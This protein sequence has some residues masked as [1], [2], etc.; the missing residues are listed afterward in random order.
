MLR[1]WRWI[2]KK[3][4]GQF[5]GQFKDESIRIQRRITPYTWMDD[6]SVTSGDGR[7]ISYI[8]DWSVTSGSVGTNRI[9]LTWISLSRFSLYPFLRQAEKPRWWDSMCGWFPILSVDYI[10]SAYIFY[11]QPFLLNV[12]HTSFFLWQRVYHVWSVKIWLWYRPNK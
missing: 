3:V 4:N 8:R 11:L 10:F 5:P 12:M 1:K 9:E 7:L 6:W 2:D